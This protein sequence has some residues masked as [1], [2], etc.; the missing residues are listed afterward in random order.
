MRTC[1]WKSAVLES[2]KMLQDQEAY[3]VGQRVPKLIFLR[4]RP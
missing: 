4:Q 3:F 2:L 1:N